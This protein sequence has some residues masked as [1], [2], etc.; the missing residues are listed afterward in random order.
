MPK[1]QDLHPLDW[2]DHPE[3]TW[4]KSYHFFPM[5]KL[6]A[7]IVNWCHSV[8]PLTFNKHLFH[9]YQVQRQLNKAIPG[10]E[11]GWA[12]TFKRRKTLQQNEEQ[13]A[14]SG[15]VAPTHQG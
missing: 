11:L 8:L 13:S 2:Q 7:D 9:L 6:P 14:P 10:R 4:E 1:S 5:K 3:H 12:A 15:P